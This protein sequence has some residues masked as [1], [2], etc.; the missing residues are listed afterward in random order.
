MVR[1]GP[2]GH[3]EALAQP[4]ARP[5]DFT[6]RSLKGMVYVGREGYITDRGLKSWLDRGLSFALSLASEGRLRTAAMEPLPVSSEDESHAC[7]TARCGGRG[8]HQLSWRFE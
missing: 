4:H 5:M 2:D 1:V 7:R 3:E 8:H 6:G